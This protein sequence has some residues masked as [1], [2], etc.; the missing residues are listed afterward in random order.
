MEKYLLKDLLNKTSLKKS[1]NPRKQ[2]NFLIECICIYVYKKVMY[3][4]SNRT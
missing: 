3:I 4:V 1:R 2:R